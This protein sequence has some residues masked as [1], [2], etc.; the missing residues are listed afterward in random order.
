MHPRDPTPHGDVGGWSYA[1]GPCVPHFPPAAQALGTCPS[2]T[3]IP[4]LHAR[5]D[6]GWRGV[7]L[8]P[9]RHPHHPR[10]PPCLAS[11]LCTLLFSLH[12]A[13]HDFFFSVLSLWVTELVSIKRFLSL[14]S[15]LFSSCCSGSPRSSFISC[16]LM[17]VPAA[18]GGL[19]DPSTAVSPPPLALGHSFPHFV[20]PSRPHLRD[21]Q[22]KFIGLDLVCPFLICAPRHHNILSA[23]TGICPPPPSLAAGAVCGD[24]WSQSSL[25]IPPY[26]TA[27]ELMDQQPYDWLPPPPASPTAPQAAMGCPVKALVGSAVPLLTLL[28][29]SLPTAALMSLFSLERSRQEAEKNRVLTNEL[30]VIL[31][32]LNN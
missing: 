6:M 10:S 14:V 17:Q 5:G 8:V 27:T 32:E 31:T 24:F 21:F 12:F 3:A 4:V 23:L 30:R 29:L 1:Q 9:G 7:V 20:P 15:P 13:F 11:V 22:P 18:G 25:S 19:R 16:H 28:S 2:S 26:P